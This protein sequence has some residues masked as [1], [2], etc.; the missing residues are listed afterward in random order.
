VPRRIRSGPAVAGLWA[1][2]PDLIR[3]GTGWS[4]L[5]PAALARAALT[6]QAEPGPAG[7]RVGLGWL[8]NGPTAAHAGAGLEAISLLRSRV[9]DR[10][11]YVVLTSRAVTVESLDDRLRRTFLNA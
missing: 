9:R 5:L 10:R 6:P 4:S 7:I 3:L 2:G 8:L 1:A 11:T